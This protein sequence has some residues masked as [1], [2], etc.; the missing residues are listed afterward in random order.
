[1]QHFL[2]FLP[3]PHGQGSFLP[4]FIRA[5][6]LNWFALSPVYGLTVGYGSWQIPFRGLILVYTLTQNR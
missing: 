4:I 2:N 3:L 1:M 5:K 6:A